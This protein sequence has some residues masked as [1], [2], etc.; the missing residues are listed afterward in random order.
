MAS[1]TLVVVVAVGGV[2][3]VAAAVV[4]EAAY[5]GRTAVASEGLS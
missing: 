5:Q 4:A 3:E 2:E 1:G